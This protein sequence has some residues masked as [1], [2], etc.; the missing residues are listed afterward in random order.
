MKNFYS[1]LPV[2][3]WATTLIEL[4]GSTMQIPHEI[5]YYSGTV[6]LEL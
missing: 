2:Q 3:S 6:T 1:Y 4:P 5:I